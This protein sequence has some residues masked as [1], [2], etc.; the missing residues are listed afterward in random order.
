MCLRRVFLVRW[1]VFR[2]FQLRLECS[3]SERLQIAVPHCCRHIVHCSRY[4]A[5]TCNHRGRT[6]LEACLPADWERK[7]TPD[8]KRRAHAVLMPMNRNSRV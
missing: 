1:V 5:I 7:Y 8:R 6:F 2:P 3:S 4:I